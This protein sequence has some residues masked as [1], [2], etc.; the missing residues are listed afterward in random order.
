MPEGVAHIVAVT[1]LA[2]CLEATVDG[3]R[4]A[5]RTAVGSNRLTSPVGDVAVHPWPSRHATDVPAVVSETGGHTFLS[6]S[7]GTISNSC[8][9]AFGKEHAMPAQLDPRQWPGRVMPETDAEIDAAVRALCLRANWPDADHTQIRTLLVPW[10]AKGWS[11]DALLT[12]VDVHADGSRQGPPRGRDHVAHDFLRARLRSWW[13][14]SDGPARPPLAGVS[15]GQW[16]RVHR[17]NIK[18]NQP[19]TAKP[20]SPAGERARE[21]TKARVRARLED[22]VERSREKARRWREVLDSLLVPGVPPPT[23]E[24]SRKLLADLPTP[25]NHVCSRCGQARGVTRKAA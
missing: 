4:T 11:V 19:R 2:P 14:P 22:P 5:V 12:A 3:R 7:A 20:L 10:F 23:F 13:S 8:S 21:A 1:A 25:A 6:V 17:R 18:L 15:F 24:D 16:W 9:Y